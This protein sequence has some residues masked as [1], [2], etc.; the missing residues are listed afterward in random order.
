MTFDEKEYPNL[1]R[2]F[3]HTTQHNSLDIKRSLRHCTYLE[4]AGALV[5]GLK[6][7]GSPWQPW[8]HGWGFNK[9]RGSDI[10]EVWAKIPD[11]VDVLM[12]HGPPLGHGDVCIPRGN[13]AGCVDLLRHVQKRIKPRYH[14]FG[15]I[16]EGYGI[17]T[18]GVTMYVNASSCN[19]R[20]QK[21]KMQA[22][23]VFDVP[24]PAVDSSSSSSSSSPSSCSPSSPSSPIYPDSA[25]NSIVAALL[26][27]CHR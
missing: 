25:L 17:T 11:E 6:V 27:L 26:A 15:H 3:R 4:D 16:H 10:D 21:H 5:Y 22:P 19:A 7:W 24:L 8:F 2:R 12:T 14:V 1:Y 20:Y 18:D 13:R 9:Q 23:I